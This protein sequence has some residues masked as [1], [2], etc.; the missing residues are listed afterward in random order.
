MPADISRPPNRSCVFKN[1]YR[2]KNRTG[3][4]YS[5]NRFVS[6]LPFSR[7]SIS[8]SIEDRSCLA[9]DQRASG[10]A[11]TLNETDTIQAVWSRSFD[12]IDRIAPTKIE[13]FGLACLV[14]PAFQIRVCPAK[15]NAL[16]RRQ[17][18]VVHNSSHFDTT[19]RQTRL[20]RR[21]GTQKPS[22]SLCG[23][24]WMVNKSNAVP[25]TA[26]CILSY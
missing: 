10:G 24:A 8:S 22:P 20:G 14:R 21:K 25:I 17:V 5:S 2:T 11:A 7:P 1:F 9:K 13:F 6:I 16:R 3:R 18:R 4:S 26:G 15:H 19:A 12:G 23:G